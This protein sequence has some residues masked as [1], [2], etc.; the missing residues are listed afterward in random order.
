MMRFE[1]LMLGIG[2]LLF[3]I[4]LLLVEISRYVKVLTEAIITDLHDKAVLG[5]VKKPWRKGIVREVVD[6]NVKKR[7]V[8]V[9]DSGSSGCWPHGGAD[10]EI[11]GSDPPKPPPNRFK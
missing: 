1:W 6:E 2:G 5:A 7:P 3:L 8:A 9:P 10:C 11:P 4:V